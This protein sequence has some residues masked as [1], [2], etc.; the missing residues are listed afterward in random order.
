MEQL[1]LV[2]SI[3]TALMHLCSVHFLSSWDSEPLN[4][5]SPEGGHP[6]SSDSPFSWGRVSAERSFGRSFRFGGGKFGAK[7]FVKFAAKFCTKFSGLFCWDIQS[8]KTSAKTSAL[9][10]HDSASA[11]LEKFQGKTS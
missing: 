2:M 3:F 7:F 8:K 9:N 6:D 1:A 10:S 5:G 11:K 4:L